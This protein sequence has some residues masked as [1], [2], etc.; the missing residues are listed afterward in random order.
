M[1]STEIGAKGVGSVTTSSKQASEIVEKAKVESSG[2]S[3][4]VCAKPQ[5]TINGTVKAMKSPINDVD[6]SGGGKSTTSGP[7]GAYSLTFDQGTTVTL[8]YSLAG[9]KDE[10]RT[11][12]PLTTNVTENLSLQ[13]KQYSLSGRLVFGS[14]T[15]QSVRVELHGVGSKPLFKLTSDT[16]EFK[17]IPHGQEVRLTVYTDILHLN[18][19]PAEIVKVVTGNLTEQNF[20]YSAKGIK[21]SGVVKDG[22]ANLA[23]ASVKLNGGDPF[24][25]QGDGAY[26]FTGV[27]AGQRYVVSAEHKH[28]TFESTTL[29]GPS[30][31][32][33]VNFAGKRTARSIT[34]K[35]KFADDGLKK[36]TV[37]LATTAP[38][39]NK[40]TTTGADGSYAFTGLDSGYKYTLSIDTNAAKYNVTSSPAAIDELSQDETGR[41]FDGAWRTYALSGN[42]KEQLKSS[43][44]NKPKIQLT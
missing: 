22:E 29:S 37:K 14:E 26:E 20:T 11:I 28:F 25:T 35:V 21:I 7:N 3:G 41:D 12:G 31:D 36:V 19:T 32:T 6:I 38:S 43:Q 17:G 34:G 42:V 33:A 18:R 8:T 39:G 13:R 23:G 40:T 27:K 9:F 24:V 2:S 15:A 5:F 1:S 16:F 44:I 30:M 10:E 4:S